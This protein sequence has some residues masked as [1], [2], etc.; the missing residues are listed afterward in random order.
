MGC[1]GEEEVASFRIQPGQRLGTVCEAEGRCLAGQGRQVVNG[2]CCGGPVVLEQAGQTL[3]TLL[4]VVGFLMLMAGVETDQ[5]VHAPTVA[6]NRLFRKKTRAGQGG[7]QRAGRHA[8]VED[9]GGLGGDVRARVAGQQA[10]QVGLVGGQ[11]LVGEVEGGLYREGVA[12]LVVVVEGLQPGVLSLEQ[13]GQGGQGQAGIG[14]EQGGGDDQGQWQAPAESGDLGERVRF[15]FRTQVVRVGAGEGVGEQ[16]SGWT[17]SEFVQLQTAS[18]ERDGVQGVAGSDQQAVEARAR[19]QRQDL[20][21]AAGVVGNHQYRLA[22]PSPGGQFRLVQG[23]LLVKC[24]G[25]VRLRDAQAAQQ[26]AQ[27]LFSLDAPGGVVAVQGQKQGAAGEPASVDRR[28]CHLQGQSRLAD[29]G[30]PRHSRDHHR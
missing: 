4:G 14:G 24:R 26:D 6:A 7:E 13:F 10:Q 18:G 3:L 17:G 28:M 15:S 8:V 25:Q 29:P 20:A 23:P 9:G 21:G 1:G 22:P 19:H 11:F 30:Q 16:G 27:C 12:V 5:V 2:R